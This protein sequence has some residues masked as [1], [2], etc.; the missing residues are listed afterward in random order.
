MPQEEKARVVVRQIVENQ[1]ELRSNV[2]VSA[3]SV[4]IRKN[5][6]VVNVKQGDVRKVYRRDERSLVG[7]K[8][9]VEPWEQGQEIYQVVSPMR[10][11]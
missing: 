5:G 9:N 10:V 6:K 8:L 2:K 7:S 11:T 3:P 4:S 1:E